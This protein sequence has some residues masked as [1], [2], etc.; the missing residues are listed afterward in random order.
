LTSSPVCVGLVT[1]VDSVGDSV[2][3]ESWLLTGGKGR[4]PL[5]CLRDDG[6]GEVVC[7]CDPYEQTQ[8]A[9]GKV[10]RALSEAG[11]SPANVVRTRL[12]VTVID[13]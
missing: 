9:L 2:G 4:L 8:R 13:R 12:Y 3:T 6:G 11:A 10:E 5:P 7:K 1:T